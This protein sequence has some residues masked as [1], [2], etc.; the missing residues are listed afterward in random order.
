MVSVPGWL[1]V[2]FWAWQEATHHSQVRA[3]QQSPSHRCGQDAERQT[4]LH[5]Q[6]RGQDRAPRDISLTDFLYLTHPH[7]QSF[8]RA[9]Q[10]VIRLWIHQ[11]LSPLDRAL[12]SQPFP[13]ACLWELLYQEPN[14]PQK[15]SLASLG[16]SFISHAS[17]PSHKDSHIALNCFSPKPA[18]LKSYVP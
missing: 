16:D 14:P 2:V 13:K 7:L 18:S 3:V 5:S 8:P 4:W 12:L 1:T 17:K 9:P 10:T 11:H 6:A 15:A